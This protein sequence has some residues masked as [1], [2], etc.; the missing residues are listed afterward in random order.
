[1]IK[2]QRETARGTKKVIRRKRERLVVGQLKPGGGCVGIP[3]PCF[4]FPARTDKN[5]RMRD[6]FLK[7]KAAAVFNNRSI[8]GGN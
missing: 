5:R 4:V 7:R 8:F 6:L 2:R 3:P 1:M